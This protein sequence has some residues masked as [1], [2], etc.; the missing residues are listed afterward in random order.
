MPDYSEAIAKGVSQWMDANT[1]AILE[2]FSQA[3][4]KAANDAIEP[5][6]G[7]IMV[8]VGK[9]LDSNR[10]DFTTAIAAAIALSYANRHPKPPGVDI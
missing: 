9:F 1:H 7:A 6:A 10:A 8:R 3:A 5:I 4:S 2:V